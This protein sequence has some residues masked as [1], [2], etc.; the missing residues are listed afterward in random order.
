MSDGWHVYLAARELLMAHRERATRNHKVAYS[1]TGRAEVTCTRCM[2]L[3]G[4]QL[5]VCSAGYAA[6]RVALVYLLRS[7]PYQTFRYQE[8]ALAQQVQAVECSLD[9]RIVGARELI[10]L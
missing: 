10:E 3:G 8:P 9:H 4:R 2:D 7:F 1:G 5:K 6:A